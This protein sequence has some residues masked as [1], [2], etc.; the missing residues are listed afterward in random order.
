MRGL[1]ARRGWRYGDQS[2]RDCLVCCGLVD[3]LPVGNACSP[4]ARR[5]LVQQ[6]IVDVVGKGRGRDDYSASRRDG[7]DHS[8]TAEHL[9]CTFG[10]K[11]RTVTGPSDQPAKRTEVMTERQGWHGE[12]SGGCVALEGATAHLRGNGSL[13]GL[14]PFGPAS[15]C[16][17]QRAPSKA[18]NCASASVPPL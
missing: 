3:D 11:A 12:Q 8:G 15:T 1:S 7:L 5:W 6:G 4:V 9:D 18:S 13:S 14:W 2:V 10:S 16:V 17:S